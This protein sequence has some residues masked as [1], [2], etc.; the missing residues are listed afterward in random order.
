M[1]NGGIELER[2]STG[3]LQIGLAV[4]KQRGPSEP[5]RGHVLAAGLLYI[6]SWRGRKEESID[7]LLSDRIK[8]YL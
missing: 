3:S 2:A 8:A 5:S 7:L 6:H 1:W 4:P